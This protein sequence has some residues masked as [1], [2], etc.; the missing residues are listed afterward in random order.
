ML[1]ILLLMYFNPVLG[2]LCFFLFMIILASKWPALK[3]YQQKRMLDSFNKNDY[4]EKLK[5]KDFLIGTKPWGRMAL[6]YGAKKAAMIYSLYMSGAIF[7]VLYI[8]R[9]MDIFIKPDMSFIMIFSTTY[10]FA[11]YYYMHGYFK[12]FLAMKESVSEKIN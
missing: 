2:S 3:K 6:N 9:T 4:S 1:V 12:K 8:I 10:L 7:L 5:I 11:S